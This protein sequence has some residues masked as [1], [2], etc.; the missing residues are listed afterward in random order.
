MRAKEFKIDS[1][2]TRPK[3][4]MQVGMRSGVTVTHIP[5]GIAVS[6]EHERGQHHNARWAMAALE[7][8]L[9]LVQTPPYTDRS[10][11]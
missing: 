9:E 1:Y 4:G 6:A 5:T 11:P 2:S 3:G 7:I 8:L 10:Q